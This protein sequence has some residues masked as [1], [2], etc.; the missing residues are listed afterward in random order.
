MRKSVFS[1]DRAS[2]LKVSS[3][4]LGDPAAVVTLTVC[5]ASSTNR[6]A[7]NGTTGPMSNVSWMPLIIAWRRN[8]FG[9]CDAHEPPWFA[10]QLSGSKCAVR[11]GEPPVLL[12]VAEESARQVVDPIALRHLVFL[13][14]GEALGGRHESP[15]HVSDTVSVSGDVPRRTDT[16]ITTARRKERLT[17]RTTI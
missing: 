4:P 1:G 12:R 8:A 7:G 5:S 6:G 14:L 2:M 16:V 9:K 10:R 3:K 15:E 11:V 13:Q 17:E